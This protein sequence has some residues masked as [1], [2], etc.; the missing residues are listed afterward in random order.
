MPGIPLEQPRAG[1]NRTSDNKGVSSYLFEK[2]ALTDPKA[3]P[4]FVAAFSQSSVG[5]T[6]PN[7]LGAWCDDGTGTQC[8]FDKS[9]CGGTSQ[10]CHG[11][12]KS[13]SEI[14][15]SS[16]LSEVFQTTSSVISKSA[17]QRFFGNVRRD[18]L[19]QICLRFFFPLVFLTIRSNSNLKLA[20]VFLDS[21]KNFV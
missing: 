4:G 13:N 12:G 16:F 15:E 17:Y 14:F 11:R 6:S 19:D 21:S 1:N 20:A 5:D 10:A 2:A 18:H 8:T 3:A 9:T 7:V